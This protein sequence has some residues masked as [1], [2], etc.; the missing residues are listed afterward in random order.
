[1]RRMR[2]LTRIEAV[3]LVAIVVIAVGVLVPLIVQT[4]EPARQRQCN[5]YLGPIVKACT[6]YQEPNGDFF[7]AQS[8]YIAGT[9][10]TFLPMPSLAILY[11][12]F[13]DDPHVFGCPH[14][15]DRP[16]I[17]IQYLPVGG[18]PKAIRHVDFGPVSGNAKCSYFYDERSNFHTIA[19]GQA[20]ACDADGMFWL[21]AKDKYPAY[22]ANWTRQPRKPNHENGMN[23]MYFDGHVRWADMVY[24]SDNPK[25]NIFCPNGGSA[26]GSGQWGADTDAYLWDGV[27]ARATQLDAP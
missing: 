2:G 26:D 1:M 19:P 20:M 23:V 21:D 18:N 16:M 7:P 4:H 10:D 12:E 17:T 8:Q 6:T 24:A 13:V 3:V 22:D 25:D 14:T 15:E 27:N 11:P 5:S 9:M